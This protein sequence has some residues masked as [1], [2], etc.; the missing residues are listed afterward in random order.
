MALV[1][2]SSVSLGSIGTPLGIAESP[3][4]FTRAFKGHIRNLARANMPKPS[5][6]NCRVV[7]ADDYVLRVDDIVPIVNAD[8]DSG[9]LHFGKGL[10][11][12]TVGMTQGSNLSPGVCNRRVVFW[13]SNV[14]D[15]HPTFLAM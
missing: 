6:N 4:C 7:S 1:V 11:V 10:L 14:C 12:P 3:H 5:P 9:F 15:C 2:V 8:L 13:S